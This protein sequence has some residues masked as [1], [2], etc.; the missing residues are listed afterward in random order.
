MSDDSQTFSLVATEKNDE[1]SDDT[2][3]DIVIKV[4][5]YTGSAER[6]FEGVKSGDPFPCG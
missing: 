3:N 5:D 4:S 6:F 2:S 1:F